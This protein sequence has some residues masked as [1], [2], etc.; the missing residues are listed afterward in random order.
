MV[1]QP[2]QPRF[3]SSYSPGGEGPQG[4]TP[5]KTESGAVPPRDTLPGPSGPHGPR[6]PAQKPPA[7]ADPGASTISRTTLPPRQHIRCFECGY[8]FNL[9]GRMH[10]T[11]CP[12]CRT[13]LDLAGYTI[14]S[15]SSEPLKTLGSI[16]ITRRGIVTSAHLL[17]TDIELA[18]RIKDSLVQA[19]NALVIHPGADFVRKEI[20]SNDLRIEPGAQVRLK[21]EAA[22]RH[23]D[24]AGSLHTE[25]Y[26]TGLVTIRSTATFTGKIHS[27]RLVVEDGATVL[28]D[29]DIGPDGLAAADK[30][31]AAF[32]ESAPPGFAS[33]RIIVAPLPEPDETAGPA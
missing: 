10:S 14:D 12:K 2:R 20:N 8:E 18:G 9:A 11:Y 19:F 1:E 27:G 25:L 31:L 15:A 32:K 4:S 24:I 17:A 26:A 23:V 28:A 13:T 5:R 33:E 30:K 7:P 29:M 3:R 21:D 16:R 22:Y 6:P